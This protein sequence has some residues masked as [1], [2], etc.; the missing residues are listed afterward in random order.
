MTAGSSARRVAVGLVL[1]LSALAPA[2]HAQPPA[3][4]ADEA[5]KNGRE[6]VKAGKWAEACD[7]FEKSQA[8][9]PQH[10]T[11]FNIAQC[12]EKVGNLATAAAAYR[13]L[14]AHDAN[15]ARKAASADALKALAPRVPKLVVSVATPPPGLTISVEGKGK[16]TAYKPNTP[17]EIDLGEYT[18]IANARGYTEQIAKVKIAGERKTTV[19]DVVLRAGASNA[20]I[21][22]KDVPEPPSR[23]AKQRRLGLILVGV[24]GAAAINGIVFGLVAE[25][26]WTE[27]RG[28]CDGTGCGTQSQLDRANRLGDR[29]HTKA[30]VSTVSLISAGVLAAAGAVVWYTAPGGVTIAPSATESSAG[31]TLSGEF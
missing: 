10:G 18:V 17:T 1:A 6:L 9:D 31:V 3:S 11:L 19:V 30:T 21:V 27:A 16:A 20:D 26:Q 7:E 29:A 24:G 23:G 28:V 8:L 2:S 14:A 12:S 22:R 15:A 4:A 13:E 5:F 25:S